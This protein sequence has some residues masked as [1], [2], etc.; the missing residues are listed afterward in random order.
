MPDRGGAFPSGGAALARSGIRGRMEGVLVGLRLMAGGL[1]GAGLLLLSLL[2]PGC[3]AEFVAGSLQTTVANARVAGLGWLGV[4]WVL[5]NAGFAAANL[6][7]LPGLDGR[8]V[9]DELRAG[10]SRWRGGALRGT[11]A[12]DSHV[13]RHWWRI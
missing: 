11:L 10:L 6:V 12:L 5:L 1:Q 9:L 3:L 4:W 8:A 7:P 13:Q 2:C